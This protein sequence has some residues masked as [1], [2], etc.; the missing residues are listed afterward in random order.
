MDSE[1]TYLERPNWL[2]GW[3]RKKRAQKL[4]VWKVQEMTFQ[5]C[6]TVI[7]MSRS[8]AYLQTAST[9]GRVCGSHVYHNQSTT[10][11]TSHK[12]N[13][14]L[15]NKMPKEAAFYNAYTDIWYLYHT[16]DDSNTDTFLSCQ[17]KVT[18]SH[19]AIK[20]MWKLRTICHR[21]IT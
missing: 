7:K 9:V 3:S 21:K 11:Q 12:H 20:M 18:V 4:M 2:F 19:A 16:N 15:S 10:R 8:I 17:F 13:A 14:K 6:E 1:T 5:S